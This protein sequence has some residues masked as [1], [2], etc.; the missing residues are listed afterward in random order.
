MAK[1]IALILASLLLLTAC[2][3]TTSSTRHISLLVEEGGEIAAI[4]ESEKVSVAEKVNTKDV[5][6]V[7]YVELLE[8]VDS[9]SAYE[10]M[11]DRIREKRLENRILFTHRSAGGDMAE[12]YRIIEEFGKME[13]DLVVPVLTPPA[14]AASE[15]LEGEIPIIFSSVVDPEYSRLMP[16]LDTVNPD[17]PATGVANAIPA[18]LILGT[19]ERLT[20]SDGRR[21]CIFYNTEQNNA[22]S[23]KE[24]AKAYAEEAGIAY[25]VI[26]Y[27]S[28]DE[29]VTKA[30]GISTDYA[31]AYVALDSSVIGGFSQVSS[32]L[33]ER[34][35]AVYGASDAMA[36]NGALCSYALD[37]R[38]IGRLTADMIIE[39]YGGTPLKDLPCVRYDDFRLVINS[40]TASELGLTI[41]RELQESAELV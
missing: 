10:G 31:Y 34:G 21:I 20:P 1:R 9:T 6:Q 32:V 40:K 12:L 18:D 3:R 24:D 2:S 16:S 23:T 36:R 5:I 27:S 8:M 25:D 28:L 35:I 11:V 17:A 38:V 30:S 15:L 26:P 7:G 29:L 37:Y 13:Y 14:Q 33:T 39:W 4:E 41:P 22:I 19:A